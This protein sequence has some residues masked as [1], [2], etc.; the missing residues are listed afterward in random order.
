MSKKS[1]PAP[2]RSFD[3]YDTKGNKIGHAHDFA[4]AKIIHIQHLNKIRDKRPDLW[5][6]YAGV[7]TREDSYGCP[8]FY[9]D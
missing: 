2:D 3:V 6:R 1:E 7:S 8:L 5:D 4:T 9:L